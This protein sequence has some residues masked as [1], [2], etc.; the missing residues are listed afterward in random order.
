MGSEYIYKNIAENYDIDKNCTVEKEEI[1]TLG[2]HSE[3]IKI[4]LKE[5]ELLD[6]KYYFLIINSDFNIRID[7]S[8]D[9]GNLDYNEPNII[10]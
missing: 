10:M 3:K 2:V 9:N 7:F 8:I 1:D 4:D 6:G 5:F